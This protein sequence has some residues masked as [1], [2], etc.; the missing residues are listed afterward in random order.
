[1]RL[2]IFLI[3]FSHLYKSV[4][5]NYSTIDKIYNIR[6]TLENK[7]PIHCNLQMYYLC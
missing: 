2:L 5:V 3:H 1:M 4:I 6:G 7:L